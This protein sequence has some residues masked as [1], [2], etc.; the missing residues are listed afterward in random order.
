MSYEQCQIRKKR[1]FITV[2]LLVGITL[3]I[4][5]FLG[6]RIEHVRTLIQLT[7]PP[8]EL[9][10][11]QITELHTW[12]KE[13]AVHLNTIEA[14]SGLQSPSHRWPMTSVNQYDQ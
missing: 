4:F 3:G 2:I 13:N 8:P 7:F 14:G 1:L 6:V 5:W 10:A 12:L 11:D 9:S